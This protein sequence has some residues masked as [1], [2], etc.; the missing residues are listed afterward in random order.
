MQS[1]IH[2]FG[3]QIASFASKSSESVN[4]AH[5][6]HFSSYI[7][8]VTH[9]HTHIRREEATGRAG[10]IVATRETG[11]RA[12]T[13]IY[14]AQHAF[15]YN[16]DGGGA[17]PHL[18][19]C[20]PAAGRRAPRHYRTLIARSS[21]LRPARLR[22]SSRLSSLPLSSSS[23]PA[24]PRVQTIRRVHDRAQLRTHRR[25][26]IW[27]KRGTS[28]AHVLIVSIAIYPPIRLFNLA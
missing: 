17:G 1:T 15:A 3:V 25:I 6:S 28:N 4:A 23:S 2:E 18:T 9:T 11:P 12:Q 10:R 8:H 20:V 19:R 21:A 14:G 16:D 22:H 13:G 24:R 7:P 26:Y 27:G 5:E